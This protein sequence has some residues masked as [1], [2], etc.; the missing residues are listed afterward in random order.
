MAKYRNDFHLF[1]AATR[2]LMQKTRPDL[3]H[4]AQKP[5]NCTKN[6]REIWAIRSE[7]SSS[8]GP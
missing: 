4:L 3:V 5:K 6:H 7:D 2:R 8:Q 1:S